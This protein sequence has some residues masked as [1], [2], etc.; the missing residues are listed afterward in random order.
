MCVQIKA[1]YKEVP[2]FKW[3][4][5]KDNPLDNCDRC[6]NNKFNRENSEN[7]LYEVNMLGAEDI[8]NSCDNT[9]GYY[10]LIMRKVKIR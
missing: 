6:R 8:C 2:S 9:K 1:N 5:H 7:L 4:R 3:I 10:I